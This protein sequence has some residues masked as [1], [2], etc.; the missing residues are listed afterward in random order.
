MLGA[1][2]YRL[3]RVRGSKD[4]MK[5]I[6][7]IGKFFMIL[8]LFAIFSITAVI[9][10]SWQIDKVSRDYTR[11]LDR[12][13]A[14]A[15]LIVRASRSGQEARS[16]IGDL[17]VSTTDAGNQAALTEY[18]SARTGFDTYVDQAASLYP[19]HAAEIADV[20]AVGHSI[21]DQDCAN[22]IKLAKAATAVP[23][24][25]HSQ[26][27]FLTECSPKFAALLNVTLKESAA[28]QAA[29][30]DQEN[31]LATEVRTVIAMTLTAVLAGLAIV[32]SI[33]FFGVRAWIVG[34]IAALSAT[35]DRLARGDFEAQVAAGNRR[36]EIGAMNRT[37]QV[38]KDA[39]L[40]KQRLEADAA[41]Q[42][43]MTEETR[44][45]AEA[46]RARA[47]QDQARVVASLGAGLEK[48]SSGDLTFRIVE[49]F[50]ADY[51]KLRTDFNT[52][53][54]NL[55][56]TMRAVVGRTHSLRA[57]GQEIAGASEDLSKRTEQQAASLEQ[58]AAALDEITATVKKTAD[59]AV[60]A[61]KVVATAK[62]DAE[63]SGQVVQQ[64]V[65][66][67]TDIESSSRQIGQIIGVID[68]IAFQT[69]L[70]ALNAGVEAARA[71]DAGKGFAV[72]ASEVRV[73]A[74]RSAE[75]A[76]EIKTLISASAAQVSQGVERVG[77]TGQA[78]ARIAEQVTQITGVVTE[79]AASAEEQA[80][81]LREVNSAVN[82]MDQVT[83]Q[84]AAMV[85]QAT[86]ASHS[87]R[88]E[89]DALAAMMD[90]F[91]IGDL[92]GSSATAAGAK[93]VE[94]RQSTPTRSGRR[95]IAA[96][97]GGGRPAATLDASWEEF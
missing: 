17:L 66:A 3:E 70:L 93:A 2:H 81:G 51:E 58:T 62:A 91:R 34:P 10:A 36:D 67:M 24:V 46:E 97:A 45:Q 87:L 95:P 65:S 84:N 18:T 80:V 88:E 40:E 44:R 61:R 54:A 50:T 8:A 90:Q 85:E 6:P 53:L 32:V 71:G 73:L 63:T 23:D 64:A 39:G 11:L 52:A 12:N 19:E 82:Q 74:Q 33:G 16:A 75:A 42:R 41:A 79:I 77:E 25:L 9:Y 26:A 35:M 14:A 83:Q 22:T 20:K 37:V 89:T 31:R 55:S 86:A 94:A 76:K 13:A 78:L 27:V 60:H 47:A 21:F 15:V 43:N 57:S 72:V 7:I 69:N 5:D 59:G 56:Q 49:A 68:E 38:F 28:M 48:L 30:T 4:F 1:A 29:W 92:G 96:M